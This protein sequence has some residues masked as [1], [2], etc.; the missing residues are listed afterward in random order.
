MYRNE[1]ALVEDILN[2]VL[3]TLNKPAIPVEIDNFDGLIGM[4]DHFKKIKSLLMSEVPGLQIIGIWG[5]G[6]VG[7]TTIAEA[8]LS[9]LFTEFESYYFLKDVRESS[10]K[11][12]LE[13]LRNE[14]IARLLRDEK[15][16]SGSLLPSQV[17]NHT[18]DRLRRTKVLLRFLL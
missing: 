14:L 6:G 4:E 7:K 13:R 2:T 5:M 12:G 10:E 11:Y 8:V 1:S 9:R 3:N 18:K 16:D 17:P 15:L